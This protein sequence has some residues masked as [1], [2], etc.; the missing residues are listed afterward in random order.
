MTDEQPMIATETVDEQPI[1]GW[2][3]IARFLATSKRRAQAHRAE[4]LEDH[5]LFD[6]RVGRARTKIVFTYPSLL[7]GWI[8]LKQ[9]R[10]QP[11]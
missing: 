2:E 5:V 6:R 10:G 1:I 4:M 9:K 11:L 3:R 8:M 7:K